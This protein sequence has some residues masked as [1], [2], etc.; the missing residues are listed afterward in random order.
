MSSTPYKI[1]IFPCKI[2]LGK[3]D[4]MFQILIHGPFNNHDILKKHLSP[5][6]YQVSV[7]EVGTDPAT[8][9]VSVSVHCQ[10]CLSQHHGNIGKPF[11]KQMDLKWIRVSQE[12]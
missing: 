3:S 7:A 8:S 2:V 1:N 6:R 11:H 12:T 10:V 5:V 4:H 9:V